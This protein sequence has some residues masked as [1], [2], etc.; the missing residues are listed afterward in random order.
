MKNKGKGLLEEAG[1]RQVSNLAGRLSSIRS[2][3]TSRLTNLVPNQFRWMI[4]FLQENIEV[5]TPELERLKGKLPQRFRDKDLDGSGVVSEVEEETYPSIPQQLKSV[6]PKYSCLQKNP[7][8]C[9][10]SQ[11]TIE[12]EPEAKYCLKCGFPALLTPEAKIR[13]NRGLYQVESFLGQR[14]MGRLYQAIQLPEGQPVVIKEYLLP[15]RYFNYE[16]TKQRQNDFTRLAG[17]NLADGRVQDFRLITPSDAIADSHE[18]RCYMVTRGN[19]DT[20][21]TLASYLALTGSLS[22]EQVR[23]ILNQVLQSLEFLHTQKFRLSSGLIHQGLAH[24]NLSLNSLLIALNFQGFFIYLCD[25]GLW[26]NQFLPPLVEAPAL[27]PAKDLK[28]LG[29]IAFY[30]L[31][32]GTVDPNTNQKLDPSLEKHWPTVNP[33]LKSFILNLIGIG[34]VDFQS[35]EVARQA[36]LKLPPEREIEP[37]RTLLELEEEETKKTKRPLIPWFFIGALGLLL[38]TALIWWLIA[39]SRRQE[40]IVEDTLTCCIE[41]ISGIPSGKF[42][43]TA[44]KNSP[45]SYVLTQ[46][47]LIAKQI[48]LEAE[49]NKRQ[50]QLQLSYQPEPSVPAAIAQVQSQQAEFAIASFFNNLSPDLGYEEFAYDGLVVFVPFSYV[51]RKN[52]LPEA[53]KGQISLEQLRQLYT[54][55]ITNWRELGGPNLPVKLYIPDEDEAVQIFQER[56]L[57]NQAAINDFKNLVSSQDCKQQDESFT[58][59]RYPEIIPCPTFETLRQVIG[60]FEDEQF[61]GIAFGSLSK[62][63]G[64]C[65]VYPLDLVKNNTDPISP[66]IQDDGK[67]V[68]PKT[69][70]CNDK[71]SYSPNYETFLNKSYPLAYPLA[72][73]YPR[74]NSR[75]PIGQKFAAILKTV[76]AQRLLSKTG[77]VPLQQ[78]EEP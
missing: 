12:E 75:E 15:Q 55:K 53:L 60:G 78:L 37:S 58:T 42:T 66:L 70:L 44:S 61:G 56:V 41:Q 48:T 33:A 68:T 36:L 7:L 40:A 29:Y 77:L 65:S 54:G 45:W 64:Q 28:D 24:G 14:G 74:D 47:N 26:E 57:V 23:Q 67:P 8:G 9:Q 76:E 6:Y 16:E 35:A 1:K 18:E 73:I 20:S 51:R 69:D 43:Y 22:S 71:G 49:L 59:A 25:L 5:S 72:V 31:A 39:R 11:Q 32:G 27:S 34:I 62:V 38:L 52:N 46:P 4:P 63:L 13:G 21:S 2:R 19:L 50:P 17:I 10:W 3:F 30:L